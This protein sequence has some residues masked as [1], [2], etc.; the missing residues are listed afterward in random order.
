VGGLHTGS[1]WVGGQAGASSASLPGC[2]LA[3][4]LVGCLPCWLLAQLPAGPSCQLA[5]S[6]TALLAAAGTSLP[7]PA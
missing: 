6:A 2:W 3:G 4:W 5:G 1:S 7:Q